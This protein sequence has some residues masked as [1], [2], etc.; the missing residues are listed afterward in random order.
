VVRHK[1]YALARQTPDEAAA[2][3]ELMD[4]DFHLFTEKSTGQDT[5]IYRAADGYRLALAHPP[6]GWP[7]PVDPSVTVSKIPAPRLSATEAAI[8]LDATGQPVLFF[9]NAGTGRGNLL[10]HRYDGNYGLIAPAS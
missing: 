3:A 9:V 4:Y 2:D 5:V 10:Y 1:S 8:R 6:N 7:G